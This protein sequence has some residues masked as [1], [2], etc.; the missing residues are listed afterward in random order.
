M[1]FYFQGVNKKAKKSNAT[2]VD[3]PEK[4]VKALRRAKR[5]ASFNDT[6][7]DEMEEE[8]YSYQP[9]LEDQ[10]ANEQVGN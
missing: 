2:D 1:Y 5:T 7:Y 4:A 10:E 3:Y 8:D 6:L 9:S